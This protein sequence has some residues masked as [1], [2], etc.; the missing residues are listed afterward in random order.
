MSDEQPALPL[1]FGRHL[2][3]ACIAV[4]KHLGGETVQV[5]EDDDVSLIKLAR[6]NSQ[7]VI[8]ERPG[9]PAKGRLHRYTAYRYEEPEPGEPFKLDPKCVLFVLSEEHFASPPDW[10]L[11]LVEDP[12]SWFNWV[13]AAIH[14]ALAPVAPLVN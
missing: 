9:D 3:R 13:T 1:E 14:E 10:R 4:M 8:V 6:V 12:H 7:L 11:Q 2:G 5:D